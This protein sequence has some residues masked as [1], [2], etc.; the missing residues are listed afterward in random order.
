MVFGFFFL[1][2]LVNLRVLH[3]DFVLHIKLACTVNTIPY[4][5][6]MSEKN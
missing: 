4:F 3:L 5:C 2:L 6:L 1:H